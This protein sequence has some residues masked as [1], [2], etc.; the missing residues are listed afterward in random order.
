MTLLPRAVL[1]LLTVAVVAPGCSR[2]GTAATDPGD[3]RVTLSP[4]TA[5]PGTAPP[6]TPEQVV[7]DPESSLLGVAVARTPAGLRVT[8]GWACVHPHCRHDRA[9]AVTDDGFVTAR[10][11]RW[12]RRHGERLLPGPG[13]ESTYPARATGLTGLLPWP[14]ASLDPGVV[15]VIGGGDGATL[16]P[17]MRTARSTDGGSTFTTVD[18]PASQGARAFGSGFVVL[19]DGR[20]LALLDHWSDDRAGRPSDRWHG[21]YASAGRDWSAYTP[22]RPDFTPEPGPAPRGFS[23]LVSL[24]ADP[25]RGGVIWT[26]TWDGRLYV[27]TDGARTFEETATR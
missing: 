15:G 22:V 26:R 13:Q 23:P 5:R 14:A 4:S 2:A 20:L 19:A 11:V 1:V 25:A 17:F 7:E 21:L 8:T 12:D 9:I 16:F 6:R 18:V 3:T 27:S 10:Y 24:E